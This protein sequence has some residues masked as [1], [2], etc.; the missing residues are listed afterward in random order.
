MERRARQGCKYEIVY[1]SEM[2]LKSF[3]YPMNCVRI[4]V[5]GRDWLMRLIA[6]SF[7]SI[8]LMLVFWYIEW[9]VSFVLVTRTLT[10]FLCIFLPTNIRLARWGIKGGSFYGW[11]RSNC[12]HWCIYCISCRWWLDIWIP[13]YVIYT[14][15]MCVFLV[16]VN[17]HIIHVLTPILLYTTI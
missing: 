7:V 5:R 10:S 11:E 12:C 4:R 15:R 6:S 17:T 9:F 3:L 2:I 14:A 16:S 1:P 13:W 8:M